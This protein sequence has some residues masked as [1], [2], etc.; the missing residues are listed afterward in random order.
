[1][2]EFD[3][4]ISKLARF[5]GITPPDGLIKEIH[6]ATEIGALKSSKETLITE[7]HPR[8]KF[9]NLYRK[10]NN[11]SSPAVFTAAGASLSQRPA[12][13]FSFSWI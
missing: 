2:Q 11:N 13:R 1:M 9:L 6:Q 8:S 7:S 3:Q 10:G 5:M 12:V 4:E